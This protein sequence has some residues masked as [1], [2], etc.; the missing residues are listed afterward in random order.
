MNLGCRPTASA[1]FAATTPSQLAC[2]GHA[3]WIE[4]AWLSIS[5]SLFAIVVSKLWPII[6][7]EG[8]KH[9]T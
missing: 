5:A 1:L 4:L 2:T 3:R 8:F 9:S 7:R 6:D